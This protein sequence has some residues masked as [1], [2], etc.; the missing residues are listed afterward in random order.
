MFRT[1]CLA[2]AALFITATSAA[3]DGPTGL[4]FGGKVGYGELRDKLSIP[5]IASFS[6]GIGGLAYGGY[7]GYR[8]TSPEGF[9]IG[10]E[11]FVEGS[12]ANALLLIGGAQIVEDVGRGL[13]GELLAGYYVG[14]QSMVY[15]KGG[16]INLRSK[17]HDRTFGGGAG[18]NEDGWRVG[19]GYEFTLSRNLGLRVGGSYMNL[20]NTRLPNFFGPG[21]DLVEK[22]SSF[23]VEAGA[24]WFF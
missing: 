16:Y 24:L 21:L 13:G 6:D 10:A 11:A 20:E 17:F 2:I 3:A 9:A 7:V 15:L 14:S 12:Q 4:Y 8:W 19:I 5:G 18:F 1:L 23:R 22:P